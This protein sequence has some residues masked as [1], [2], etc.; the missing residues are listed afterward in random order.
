MELT[1]LILK[2]EEL[3]VR[4]SCFQIPIHPLIV[5][6]QNEFKTPTAEHLFR[7]A[8]RRWREELRIY[9]QNLPESEEKIW[10][11]Q[12]FLKSEKFIK[13]RFQNECYGSF[14]N[15]THQDERGFSGYI[16]IGR[17]QGNIYFHNTEEY[18]TFPYPKYLN[19]SQEKLTEYKIHTNQGKIYSFQ[20]HNIEHFPQA[21][22]LR[23]WAMIYLNQVLIEVYHKNNQ[24]S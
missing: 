13:K 20:H 14:E 3:I 23:T 24:I 9:A 5:H 21:L 22:L 17:N 16:S 15:I 1:D 2:P 8:I 10:I 19:I 12:T 6:Y 4:N 11:T 7:P 18:H